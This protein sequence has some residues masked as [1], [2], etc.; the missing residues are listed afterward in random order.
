MYRYRKDFEVAGF[1]DIEDRYGEVGCTSVR[2]FIDVDNDGELEVVFNVGAKAIF[3]AVGI[4]S[5]TEK[6]SSTQNTTQHKFAYMPKIVDDESALVYGDRSNDTVYCVNLSD[7]S[8]RWSYTANGD[9]GALEKSEYGVVVG[10]DGT[11]GEVTVLA[12]GDGSELSGWPVSFPQ[13]EQLLGAG[14]LDEDGE[15]EIFLNDNSG[16]YEMRNRDGSLLFSGSSN[17][18]H[19]DRNYIGDIDPNHDGRELMIIVDDDDSATGEGD[20]IVTLDKDGNQVNKYTCSSNKPAP[21]VGNIRKDKDGLEVAFGL[22]GTGKF[23]LL[24][25]SLN[26]LW[27]KTYSELN[28]G[29]VHLGYI[30]DEEYL[31][32]TVNTGESKNEGF[33]VFDRFGNYIGQCYRRGWDGVPPLRK[34]NSAVDAVLPDIDNDGRTE[35][36]LSRVPSSNTT[37]SDPIFIV[38]RTI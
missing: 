10:S 34:R 35:L 31:Q 20:E 7:G 29:Q 36:C 14:D 33:W 6:W 12:F 32:I 21:R 26:E 13:H 17:H 9:L 11:G 30:G 4:N 37:D 23:G 5:L 38:K 24:D 28:G 15:Q 3:K 18:A 19:I 16:N 25:G 2:T 27:T 8:L 22:E 1:I